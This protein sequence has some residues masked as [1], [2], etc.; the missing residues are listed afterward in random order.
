MR[1]WL[2]PKIKW[3][4][5]KKLNDKFC[6]CDIKL[7]HLDKVLWQMLR[8]RQINVCLEES[9]DPIRFTLKPI[10]KNAKLIK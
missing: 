9:D 1:Y 4:T 8:D 10:P 7:I 2:H 5:F 3:T 6:K